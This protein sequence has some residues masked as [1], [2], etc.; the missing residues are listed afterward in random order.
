MLRCHNRGDSWLVQS[1]PP[2]YVDVMW[3]QL[4][5]HSSRT[6][7]SAFR[8]RALLRSLGASAR[9]ATGWG[10]AGTCWA[11]AAARG[12]TASAVMR[13]AA[14]SACPAA[15]CTAGCST[16]RSKR[17]SPDITNAGPPCHQ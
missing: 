7:C 11:T 4:G 8:G 13:L 17:K 5:R 6:D 16:Y 10:G 1:S 3:P 9:L 2:F 12:W 14:Y 15:S